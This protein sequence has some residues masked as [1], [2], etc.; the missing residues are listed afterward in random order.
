MEEQ[1][2]SIQT[3]I[4]YIDDNKEDVMIKVKK[5]REIFIRHFSFDVQ[6][7]TIINTIRN[8]TVI[9]ELKEYDACL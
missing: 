9:K 4:Q 2:Q 5:C 6:F 7:Q 3:H 1:V 8:E